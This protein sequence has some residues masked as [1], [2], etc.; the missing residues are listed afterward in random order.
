MQPQAE[1]ERDSAAGEGTHG[2]E[3]IQDTEGRLV[4]CSGDVARPA[5][6]SQKGAVLHT[7]LPKNVRHR[8]HNRVLI[9]YRLTAKDS[10]KAAMGS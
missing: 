3:G 7:S 4:H 8:D 10:D 5:H 2:K 9:C 6:L 1:E